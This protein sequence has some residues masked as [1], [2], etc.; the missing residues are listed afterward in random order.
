MARPSAFLSSRRF[1]T[2]STSIPQLKLSKIDSCLMTNLWFSWFLN[3]LW[4]AKKYKYKRFRLSSSRF[5]HNRSQ[6][7]S[8]SL[9]KTRK[10]SIRSLICLTKS[11]PSNSL[12][13]STWRMAKT[14]N[15]HLINSSTTIYPKMSTKL[16]VLSNPQVSSSTLLLMPR[17]NKKRR[18][19]L[20]CWSSICWASLR[21]AQL[22]ETRIKH[23]MNSIWKPWSNK[24]SRRMQIQR[25]LNRRC[26]TWRTWCSMKTTLMIRTSMQ[27]KPIETDSNS[28]GNSLLLAHL[29]KNLLAKMILT[30]RI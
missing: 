30:T 18:R 10:T 9:F 24:K 22:V 26:C 3:P 11:T 4:R 20:N 25:T 14:L 6:V 1:C 17:F 19:T 15:L 7:N 13:A 28:A 27:V 2:R 21:E 16:C 23:I 8:T 29:K 5:F 12:R